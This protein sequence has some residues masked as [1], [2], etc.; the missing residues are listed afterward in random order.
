VRLGGASRALLCAL[1]LALCAPAEANQAD[2]RLTPAW[3]GLSQ[4]AAELQRAG[5]EVV[6]WHALDWGRLRSSDALALLFPRSPLSG[7]SLARFVALGGTL[8]LA[9]DFGSAEPA[10]AAFGLKRSPRPRGSGALEEVNALDQSGLGGATPRLLTNHAAEFEGADHPA[11]GFSSGGAL[12]VEQQP[13]GS[14]PGSAGT[15]VALGDPSVLIDWML[16]VEENR[17]FAR[18]LAERLCHP[19][20]PD[21]RP[22]TRIVLLSHGFAEV[23][24]PQPP[25]EPGL[26]TELARLLVPV[27][28]AIEEGEARLLGD[29]AGRLLVGALLLAALLWIGPLGLPQGAG[30]S[31][32]LLVAPSVP[33]SRPHSRP[34]LSDVAALLRE[35]LIRFLRPLHPAAERLLSSA[36]GDRRRQLGGLL[37]PVDGEV[38]AQLIEQLE[39]IGRSRGDALPLDSHDET[40]VALW[41][42]AERLWGHRGPA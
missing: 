23:G 1:C 9:D 26:G 41:R 39:A 30:V 21:R 11:F 4:F 32:E 12:V 15:F 19:G 35:E 33:R 34:A 28:D 27:G 7:A 20:S 3:N 42:L 16:Q 18:A 14:H 8:L 36:P 5:C 37:G 17:R 22:T 38:A 24:A 29:P 25:S 40:I 2:Y 13:V 31:H 6:E 10:F